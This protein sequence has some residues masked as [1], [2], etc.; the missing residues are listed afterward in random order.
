MTLFT[1]KSQDYLKS[2]NNWIKLVDKDIQHI[3][4]QILTLPKPSFIN[5][6][7]NKEHKRLNNKLEQFQAERLE[8]F[9][10]IH[11]MNSYQED[12]LSL[13]LNEYSEFSKYMN[14]K[15]K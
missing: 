11:A 7:L 2:L 1:V 15:M 3:T 12:T 8:V 14:I 13:D 10:K 6:G 4:E 9:L 5:F